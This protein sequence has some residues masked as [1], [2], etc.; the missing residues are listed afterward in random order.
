MEPNRIPVIVAAGQV[1]ERH[2]ITTAVA[3]AAR[4]S[5]AALAANSGLR[6]RVQRI[7]MVSVVFSPVSDRPAAELVELLGLRGVTAESTTAGGNIPQWLVTRA[8]K[9]IAEG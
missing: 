1:T 6:E 2:E 3:L 8:A 5:E 7:S 4:A 9:E